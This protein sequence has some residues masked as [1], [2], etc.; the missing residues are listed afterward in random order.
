[1]RVRSNLQCETDSAFMGCLCVCFFVD[2]NNQIR[3]SPNL[4]TGPKSGS[5]PLSSDGLFPGSL[6]DLLSKLPRATNYWL[7]RSCNFPDEDDDPPKASQISTKVHG[8]TWVVTWLLSH[9]SV[10]PACL[11]VP[12]SNDLLSLVFGSFSLSGLMVASNCTVQ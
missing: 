12:S 3:H 7:L 1:M 10:S 5:S 4:A 2:C 6:V 8:R 11:H 9:S